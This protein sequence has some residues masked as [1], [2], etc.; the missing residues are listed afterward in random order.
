MI[1]LCKEGIYHTNDLHPEHED[2]KREKVDSVIPHLIEVLRFE[3]DFTLEDFFNIVRADIAL[4]T[5]FSGQLGNHP[6]A[7]F[8]EEI[9]KDCLEESRE[10]MDY[11]ELSWVAEQF[12]YALFYRQHKDDVNL[13]DI[14]VPLDE[15][16]EISIYVDVHGWGKADEERVTEGV[17]YEGYAIEFTPLYRMKHLPIKL[18][19]AFNIYPKN[20]EEGDAIIEG[21]REFTVFD[22]FGSI[23]SEISFVGLPEDRDREWRDIID[24]EEEDREHR[25]NGYTD[26]E[27]EDY[28]KD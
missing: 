19:F 11:I 21:E 8:I 9:D 28:E 25:E 17:E 22:V 4:E 1:T 7:P 23:L 18:N 12:D 24:I 26:Y 20:M 10:E 3:E 15:G 6:L 2:Y 27:E 5:V 16:N 14:S 13:G